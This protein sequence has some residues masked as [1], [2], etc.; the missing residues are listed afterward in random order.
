M[1]NQIWGGSP[2]YLKRS[3]QQG[4]DDIGHLVGLGQHGRGRLLKNLTFG[5]G[6]G[7]TGVVGVD[8]AAAGGLQ[9]GR[10][11][12]D[13]AEG[14]FHLILIGAEQAALLSQC[15]YVSVC[16]VVKKIIR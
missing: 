15:N 9:V 10:Q 3:F 16:C 11:L 6:S 14:V 13:V 4:Q 1:S 12:S 2:P 5:Q 7:F 8:H